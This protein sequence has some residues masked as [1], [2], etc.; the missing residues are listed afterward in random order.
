MQVLKFGGSSVADATNIS[1]VTSI[2]AEA[3]KKDRTILVAS[4]IGGCTD[5]LILTGKL[6]SSKDTAYKEVISQMEVRHTEIIEQLIPAGF[7]EP[8]AARCA[9]L[10]QK[11]REICEGI[12]LVGELTPAS[13]DVVMSF[14]EL[15][16]TSVISAKL[17]SIGINN[18]WTDARNF[19][20]TKRV[21]SFNIVDTDETYR[22]MGEYLH[23]NGTR[24]YV[25][26][27]F[28]ASDY[29]DRTTTLGRGGSDYTASLFAVGTGAR[30]LE[31]W[32]DVSGM[33]TADPRIVPE[34]RTIEHISY[35][36][37]LELSHFGAKV[38]Y[39]PTIQPVVRKGIPIIVKNTF[40]PHGASTT[41]ERYPPENK[42]KIRG[43]SSSNRIALLSLEGSGMVGIPGYSGRFFTA[44]ANAAVNVILIT[45]ASSLH[46]MC[47]AVEE[48]DAERAGTA[49]D[50]AF[51]YEI[52]INRVNRV[53]V[54]K[55]F[56][57]VTLVGD[58]MKNQSGT[59]GRMFDALGRA[60]IN[61]RAIAQG[62]S[63]RNISTIIA[64]ADTSNAI[65]VIHDEFF[66]TRKR[67]INLFIAGFGNVGREL[68]SL[69]GAQESEL[70]SRRNVNVV[71]TGICTSRKMVVCKEGIDPKC[72]E[73]LLEKG[74]RADINAFIRQAS[75]VAPRNAVF[76]D[77]TADA[78]VAS[79]Y[80]EIFY[81]GIS[82]VTC[83]KI[84]LAS[85]TTNYQSLKRGANENG[86]RFLY[87]TTAGAALPLLATIERLSE[88]GEKIISLEAILSGTLNYLFSNYDG[89]KTFA[90]LIKEAKEAGYTEP[91]P[92]TDLSGGDVV[93]KCTIIARE[94]GFRI[95]QSEIEAEPAIES[96]LMQGSTDDFYKRVERAEKSIAEMFRA[97][98]ERG[99]RLRYIATIEEGKC[100]VG[101]KSVAPDHPLY[102]ICGTNN[103]LMIKTSNYPD[104]VVI[105]GAGA[106]ARVTA[107]GVLNDILRAAN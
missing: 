41:I 79:L 86:V 60:G 34:A 8:V 81:K 99:E 89:S 59:G 4:A 13:A 24:L 70:S 29:E 28:I 77:C 9:E 69:I 32:T 95:E 50:E 36:E 54:E 19:I 39:P 64:A 17:T 5:K 98:A 75:F 73:E 21:N 78:T 49:V 100:T 53:V 85:E 105:S 62:S 72:A 16:S 18:V 12:S 25:V 35:K 6:A 30:V 83:N 82:V 61:L 65:K 20:K 66:G 76:A 107:G 74:E 10:F 56:S 27:G 52:S 97:A 93:R 58:D 47:V 55:G 3:V 48:A 43:I 94:C 44:L 42:S 33:M 31:I 38:V 71:I 87:E 2:V 7:R 46:T 45:Q 63:E 1:K 14:G 37:A 26:P 22:R 67:R 103:S 104:G 88:S 51:A 96:S 11:L 40:D 80:G 106:G 92:R 68:V 23:A 102:N 84:A 57:I 90:T 101:V 15:L 91:D